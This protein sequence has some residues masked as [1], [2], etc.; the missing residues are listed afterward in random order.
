[1]E[2][3]LQHDVD[4]VGL[5]YLCEAHNLGDIPDGLDSMLM[6]HHSTVHPLHLAHG[7]VEYYID[8][9]VPDCEGGLLIAFVCAVK[10]PREP[11]FNSTRF[12]YRFNG[13]R[14]TQC[15]DGVFEEAEARVASEVR[16]ICTLSAGA[17]GGRHVPLDVASTRLGNAMHFDTEEGE[18]PPEEFLLRHLN[19]VSVD[20]VSLQEREVLLG[21]LFGRFEEAVAASGM[22]TA[23]VDIYAV[24]GDLMDIRRSGC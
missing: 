8:D 4:Q 23:P 3:Q 6:R 18:E 15:A 12:V 22:F 13:D 17:G 19:K 10:T 7:D 14:L 24:V 21:L 9:M 20:V 11:L 16:L 2:T 5:Q 1:M